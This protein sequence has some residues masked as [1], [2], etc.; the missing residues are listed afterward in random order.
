MTLSIPEVRPPVL[1]KET[2][3]MLDEFRSF[4]HVFRNVYGF[5]LAS[6]KDS[7]FAEQIVPYS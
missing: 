2:A 3:K 6:D 7:G 5:N 1:S 4:R